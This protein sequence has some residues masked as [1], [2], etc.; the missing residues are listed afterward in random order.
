MIERE[1]A[2]KIR[3]E[4]VT[5]QRKDI[6]TIKLESTGRDAIIHKELTS[7]DQRKDDS[8]RDRKKGVLTET[9]ISRRVTSS[10]TTL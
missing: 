10:D 6:N 1:R 7:Q 8:Q 5:E 9:R 2:K 4:A 3:K